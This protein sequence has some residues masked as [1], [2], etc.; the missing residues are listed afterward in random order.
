MNDV[1]NILF[2]TADQWRGDCLSAMDHPCVRTPHLD[3]LAA[4]GVLFAQHY[5]QAV[6][7]G[8][9]RASLHTGLYMMNH[10]SVTNGTPLDR[11]HANWAQ[12]LRAAG[13]DPVLFGYTDTSAD[14]RDHP[15]D[16]PELRTY[17]GVLPGM[18]PEVLLN[19]SDLSTW[20][21]SYTHLTLPT[22]REV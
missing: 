3:T 6:P 11:R 10:R 19:E 16:A 1:P 2:I 8:P 13:Y 18:R 4:S 20:A 9:S 21:V 17:E 14:P 22:N 15:P 5:C 12:R 7:C